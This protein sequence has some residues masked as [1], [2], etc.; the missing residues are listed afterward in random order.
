MAQQV[1]AP[2]MIVILKIFTSNY[3]FQQFFFFT[4]L[5]IPAVGHTTFI[6]ETFCIIL[7][8]INKH[9]HLKRAN[10]ISYLT[11]RNVCYLSNKIIIVITLRYILIFKHN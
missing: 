6:F 5:K 1:L 3:L 10:S 2:R 7:H 8:N 11:Y 9:Y 4:S